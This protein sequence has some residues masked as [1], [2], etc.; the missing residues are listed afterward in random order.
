MGKHVDLK[1]QVSCVP[2]D[3]DLAGVGNPEPVVLCH[4][5]AHSIQFLYYF[6]NKTTNQKNNCCASNCNPKLKIML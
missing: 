5:R 4:L 6:F 2:V 3:S 1:K